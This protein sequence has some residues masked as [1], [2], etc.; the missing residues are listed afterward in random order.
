MASS[1][2][3]RPQSATLDGQEQMSIIEKLVPYFDVNVYGQLL[4]TCKVM[5]NSF[6]T[7]RTVALQ[8]PLSLRFPVEECWSGFP[9]PSPGDLCNP[10]IEPMSLARAGGFFTTELPGKS[11]RS[12]L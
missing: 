12:E 3:W 9:F 2:P 11:L 10:G 5:P 8:V 1:W 4:F 7:P 6:V